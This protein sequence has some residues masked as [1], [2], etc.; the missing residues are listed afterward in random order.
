MASAGPD[1]QAGGFSSF[2]WEWQ[3]LG[4][5]IRK[6]AR[7]NRKG[8][9]ASE[10]RG[11]FQSPQQLQL[12]WHIQRSSGIDKS[13][14]LTWKNGKKFMQFHLAAIL[15]PAVRTATLINLVYP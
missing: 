14:K 11:D 8:A 2:Y 5:S 7:E 10:P 4:R 12:T 13:N 15:T 6:R 1:S 9:F 3:Q